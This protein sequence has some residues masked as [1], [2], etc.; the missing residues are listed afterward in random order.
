VIADQTG[1]MRVFTRF[2]P[3]RIVGHGSRCDDG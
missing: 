3:E 1:F 2:A